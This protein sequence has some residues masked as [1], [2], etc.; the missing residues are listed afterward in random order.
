MI[1]VKVKAKQQYV[2]VGKATVGES[3]VDKALIIK[4]D[5]KEGDEK[6]GLEI[7][8]WPEDRGA[9]ISIKALSNELFVTDSKH[10]DILDASVKKPKKD[11]RFEM[12][13]AGNS[14]FYLRSKEDENFV[15][16][17]VSAKEGYKVLMGNAPR[18][19]EEEKFSMELVG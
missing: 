18:K 6:F 17:A 15:S 2:S 19:G 14:V 11:E 3:V 10:K 8:S 16:Y 4:E 5:A 12:I 1:T 9:T 13:D 7:P